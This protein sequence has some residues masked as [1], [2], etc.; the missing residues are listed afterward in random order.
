MK[1]IEFN[2]T[3]CKTQRKGNAV[4]GI[5]F[6]VGGFR[7]NLEATE[8]IGIKKGDHI[9]FLQDSETAEWYVEKI[10][11][12][13]F[14]LHVNKNISKGVIFNNVH[15][16]REIAGSVDFTGRSGRMQVGEMVKHE[17]RK[18][19]HVSTDELINE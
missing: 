12:G 2:S 18:L 6:K 13:G 1:L 11:S 3:N 17:G 7:F 4:I 5:D 15:I 14:E 19:F 16:A 10:S 8:L 9:Q